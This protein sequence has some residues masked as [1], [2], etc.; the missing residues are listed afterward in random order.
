MHESCP[1]CRSTRRSGSVGG[2]VV[3]R[4][5]WILWSR[6]VVLKS[7]LEIVMKTRWKTREGVNDFRKADKAEQ[8]KDPFAS[9]ASLPAS[10][11]LLQGS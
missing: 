11:F 2:L 4:L 6:D 5:D 8:I 10:F 7:R 3:R 1:A 9:S